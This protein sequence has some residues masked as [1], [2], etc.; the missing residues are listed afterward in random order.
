M[1]KSLAPFTCFRTRCISS[2][3][4][5]FAGGKPY[6]NSGAESK[7]YDELDIKTSLQLHLKAQ[8]GLL[9][10]FPDFKRWERFYQ[11]QDW[12]LTVGTRLHSAIFSCN[13]GVPAIVTNGDSRARETCEYLGIPHRPDFGTASDLRKEYEELDLSSMN[14][15]YSLLY[16]DFVVYLKRHGLQQTPATRERDHFQFPQIERQTTPQVQEALYCDL[17]NLIN[18]CD[19]RIRRCREL[20]NVGTPGPCSGNAD[21]VEVGGSSSLPPISKSC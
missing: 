12:C 16:A 11:K 7:P 14:R 9:R 6:F 18:F 2:I 21:V 19:E 17:C 8:Q 15:K 1:K 4:C 10:F 13:R 3:C 20:D 5:F